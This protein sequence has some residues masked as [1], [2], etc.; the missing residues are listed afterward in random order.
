MSS[1]IAD[2]VKDIPLSTVLKEKLETVQAKVD[3]LETERDIL[4][5]NL[6]SKESE[7]DQLKRE[8]N[9]LKHELEIASAQPDR[10]HEN[11]EKILKV[12]ASHNESRISQEQV[13]AYAGVPSVQFEYY[14]D[15]LKE[16]KFIEWVSG[17]TRGYHYYSLTQRGRKY[18]MDHLPN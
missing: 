4:S 15:D 5:A 3:T 10:L 18:V 1:W 8:I 7:V 11:A 16:Q 17:N 14:W 6:R 13:A 2:L 12:F 9:D